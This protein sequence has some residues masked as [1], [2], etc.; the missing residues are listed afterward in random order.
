MENQ[1][2]KI[3]QENQENKENQEYKENQENQ[4]KKDKKNNRET[5]DKPLVLIFIEDRLPKLKKIISDSSKKIFE[6]VFKIKFQ[7]YLSDLQKKQS[8]INKEFN[9]NSQIIDV[10]ETE[11]TFKDEL[12]KNILIMNFL[13]T[14]FVL[15]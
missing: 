5:E 10:A 1:E 7:D 15:Y 2:N 14:S 3:N 9:V 8:L 4:E 6:K 12:F 11:Q 13:K